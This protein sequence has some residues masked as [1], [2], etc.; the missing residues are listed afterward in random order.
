[1]NNCT[2]IS[3]DLAK[4]VFQVCMWNQHHK[5]LSNKKVKRA[6]L[7]PLMATVPKYRGY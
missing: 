1:M 2:L 3:V 5:V 6:Q 4:N 7:M